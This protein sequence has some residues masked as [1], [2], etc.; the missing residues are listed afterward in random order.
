MRKTVKFV[1][2]SGPHI[3]YDSYSRIVATPGHSSVA[4][5]GKY[6]LSWLEKGMAEGWILNGDLREAALG[7]VK[8]WVPVTDGYTG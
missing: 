8:K 3:I 2:I 1:A 4:V 5:N 7:T 6:L